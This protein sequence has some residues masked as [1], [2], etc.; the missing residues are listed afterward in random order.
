[1]LTLDVM[2]EIKL[3]PVPVVQKAVSWILR[4]NYRFPATRTPITVEHWENLPTDGRPVYLAMNHTDRYNYWP[5]QV[6]LAKKKDI[7]TAT[8]VKGKYYNHPV[9][10]R[11][12]VAT[13][14]IPTPSRGYVLTA[15]A[16]S[17]IGPPEG[18]LYRILRDAI[19]GASSDA[20]LFE[21]CADTKYVEHVDKL[22]GTPR[23]MLG[24]N[25]D[26]SRH[27][28]VECQREVFRMMMDEFIN[29]NQQAFDVGLRVLVFPEGTRSVTLG[30]GKP[31]LAQMALRTGATIVPVGCN[32]SNLAYPSNNPFS[33]GGKITYRIGEPLTPEDELAAYRIDEEFRPFTDEANEYSDKFEAV[34]DLVMERIAGLLDPEYLA[35]DTNEVQGANR[36]L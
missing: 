31:G 30:D 18:E 5:F 14:N 17:L 36:F 3:T 6:Q 19:E 22:L 9:T 29:L 1:M 8:W 16:A 12:M 33:S 4:A 34:T 2:R 20:E 24:L 32:G 23:D 21:K 15:D 10:Q 35:G 27:E 25:F 26:P 7:F 28:Y 11:F 13:N